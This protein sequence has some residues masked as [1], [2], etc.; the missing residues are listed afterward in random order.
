MTPIL[1]GINVAVFVL[2]VTAGAGFVLSDGRVEARFG[3]DPGPLVERLYGSTRFALIYLLDVLCG[4]VASGWWDRAANSA[5]APG[6][7]ASPHCCF[8]SI[9]W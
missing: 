9:R 1:V 2:L 6:A 8:S 5:G 3:S 7:P 4:N